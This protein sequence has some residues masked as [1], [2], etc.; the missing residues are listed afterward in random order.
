MQFASLGSG[1]R[2]N[3][4]LIRSESTTLMVDLGF[5]TKETLRRLERLNCTPESINAIL[6]THEHTDHVSGVARFANKFN[7][8]VWA[9][10]GTAKSDKLSSCKLS[11][12]NCHSDF[13]VGDIKITPYPVP[14]DASEPCQFVFTHKE[15]RLGLLTDTGSITTHIENTLTGLDA[16]LLEFNHDVELLMNGSYSTNLKTRVA[17]DYGHLNNNQ[18]AAL[19]KKLDTSNLQSL[20]ALHLSEKNNAVDLV[21]DILN[22]VVPE[23]ASII[24]IADQQQGLAWRSLKNLAVTA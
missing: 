5:S 9:T 23:H 18:S 6:V 8:P 21:Y 7:I 2:G 10:S 3:A 12:I 22:H 11:Y 14:H 13:T 19:L 1:S 16:L 24:E 20:V 4:T 17:G 15:L